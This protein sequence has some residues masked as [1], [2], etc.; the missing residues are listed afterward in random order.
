MLVYIIHSDKIYTFRLPKTISGSFILS[1]YDNN[2]SKRNLLSIISK[3]D[4][5]YFKSSDD[6]KII[7]SNNVVDE[8]KLVN[9]RFYKLRLLREDNVF[10][11][12]LPG[13]SNDFLSFDVMVDSKITIGKGTD[14]SFTAPEAN[15]LNLE[16]Y[17]KDYNFFLFN[18]NTKIP[19]YVNN[20]LFIEG[21]LNN[22]DE[23]FIMGL[24]IIV[25]GKTILINGPKDFISVNS[26][27]LAKETGLL[28]KDNIEVDNV[29][30][31]NFFDNNEFFSKSPVF[32][33]KIKH[34]EFEITTPQAKEEK[35][36]SPI[37]LDIVPSGL[38]CLT[39]V[40]S[41]FYT[42]RSYSKGQTDKESVVTAIVMCV[43]MLF[44]SLV[45]PFIEKFYN[46][47]YNKK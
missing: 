33:K 10:L 40:L 6:A 14:I 11:Y 35:Y 34:E 15:G 22:F 44:I 20:E 7:E 41:G 45:W 42:L 13:F 37:L 27:N 25:V 24:K 39:S 2:G 19:I 47:Y 28:A 9:Y 21:K 16:L 8:S 12:V 32:K 46:E 17:F 3:D 30:H 1:D 29:V 23:I 36:H 43:V 4:A 38:M 18:K 5:W 31:T 26:K